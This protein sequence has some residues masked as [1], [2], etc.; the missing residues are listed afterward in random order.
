[1]RLTLR[2]LLAY[3]ED[4]LKP[5]ESKEIG[6]KIAESPVATSLAQRIREVM[7]R[8]R[9]SVEDLN[10]TC[11]DPNLVAEYLDGSLT[12]QEVADVERVCLGSDAHLAEVA[13]CHQI[14]TLVLGEPIEINP[15][16]RE[17]MYALADDGTVAKSDIL[18]PVAAADRKSVV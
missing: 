9:L 11:L 10:E 17:R 6:Q 4:E 15:S 5:A 18:V 14:L 1:M 12:P 13:A 16:S 7:R 2:T 8:R 3:L